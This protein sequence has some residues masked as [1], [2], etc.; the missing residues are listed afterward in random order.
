MFEEFKLNPEDAPA[1][2][3]RAKPESPE[4][5]A[6]WERFLRLRL[7]PEER[8]RLERLL[9][10]RLKERGDELVALCEELNGH[11]GYEDGFY[12]FYHQSWKVYAVQTLT[13]KTVSFLRQLLPE[14]EL[15]ETFAKIIREGT[16]K[17]FEM[18]H[19]KDWD[20]HTRPML[21]AFCHAKYMIEVAV[22]YAD[23]PAPPQPMPSG[24]AGLL[25]LYDL[26]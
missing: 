12:R 6:R 14:R 22:R 23:L 8:D 26:R 13:D 7:K 9:L 20:R 18:E 4:E 11:W 17:Q 1:E 3:K 15:N 19:N 24:W 16:G 2:T 5:K 25:Y 21:E 10:T